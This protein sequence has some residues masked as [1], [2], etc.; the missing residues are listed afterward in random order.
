MNPQEFVCITK[1]AMD[2]FEKWY[3]G[4]SD[5]GDK[6][7]LQSAY[8]AGLPNGLMTVFMQIQMMMEFMGRKATATTLSS[9]TH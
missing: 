3:E 8:L 4:N 5:K 9:I 7:A 6:E 2:A 1:D